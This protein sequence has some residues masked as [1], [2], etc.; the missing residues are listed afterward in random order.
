MS[1]YTRPPVREKVHPSIVPQIAPI[2]F[3]RAHPMTD[4]G[5]PNN[6]TI[7]RPRRR[8]GRQG[9]GDELLL[10]RL[11]P[12]RGVAPNPMIDKWSVD[13]PFIY[14]NGKC[15][16]WQPE[17]LA[18]FET[19]LHAHYLGLRLAWDTTQDPKN[20]VDELHNEVLRPGRRRRWPPTGTHRRRV[21]ED[22]RVRRLRL[23]ASAA[24]DA[25][26]ADTKPET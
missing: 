5:E 18:N 20:I 2:T 6:K 1:T 21:G 12:G 17:T 13:I 3:S 24:L 26:E 16:Y 7:T 23:R 8:L 19:C 4:D 15:K 11:L 14:T 10:L 22:P 25:G 9:R